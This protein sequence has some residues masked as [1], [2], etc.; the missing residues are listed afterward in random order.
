MKNSTLVNVIRF[1]KLLFKEWIL[2]VLLAIDLLFLII[3]LIFTKFSPPYFIYILIAVIGIIW[4]SYKVYESLLDKFPQPTSE[5]KPISNLTISFVEGNEYNFRF[6][7]WDNDRKR[8]TDLETGRFPIDEISNLREKTLPNTQMSLFIRIENS[9]ET[10]VKILSVEGNIEFNIPFQFMLSTS[11]DLE[12]NLIIFPIEIDCRQT[13][14]FKLV[15]PIF[16]Y[17]PMTDAQIAA[18][19]RNL[20][21]EKTKVNANVKIEF[22]NPDGEIEECNDSISISLLPLCDLYIGFWTKT[23]KM[24]LVKLTSG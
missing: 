10:Q 23:E 2:W 21:V 15:A 18:R 12:D 16:P 17:T 5:R 14:I 13:I 6:R 11:L 4:A 3:Q 8:H 1:L 22:T 9:G 20:I 19:T 7:K 24:D